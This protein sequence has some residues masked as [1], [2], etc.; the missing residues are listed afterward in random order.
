MLTPHR[1]SIIGMRLPITRT[2]PWLAGAV[3]AALLVSSWAVGYAVGGA[4]VAAPHW[5]YIPIALAASRF[6]YLGA[7]LASVLA[8]ALA[9]PLLPLEVAAG[10][11]QA[12]TDWATRSAFF[13][14]IGRSSPG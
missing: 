3:I 4:G 10:L 6:G 9:G 5:F 11:Q 12:P 2:S 8:G 13:L 7:A 1:S 14:A